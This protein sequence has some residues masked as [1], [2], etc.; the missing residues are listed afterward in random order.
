MDELDF[1][2]EIL[3]PA[4]C[5][6]GEF[7]C[8]IGALVVLDHSRAGEEDDSVVATG[9]EGCGEDVVG[10]GGL[11]GD[12]GGEGGD[13]APVCAIG[14]GASGDQLRDV[15]APVVA[16]SGKVVTGVLVVEFVSGADLGEVFVVGAKGGGVFELLEGHP[17]GDG[18]WA[19]V[20][21][22]DA[23][24]A[25]GFGG[26]AVADGGGEVV[27]GIVPEGGEAIVIRGGGGG[28]AETAGVVGGGAF[29]DTI[30]HTDGLA[31]VF[32]LECLAAWERWG[33]DIPEVAEDDVFANPLVDEFAVDME[34]DL[35]GVGFGGC[36]IGWDG[37][38][39]FFHTGGDGDGFF[40][41]A[42]FE[43][44]EALAFF[45]VSGV[46]YG[47]AE[48]GDGHVCAEH[49]VVSE[50]SAKERE[51]AVFIG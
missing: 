1:S 46:E 16:P 28:D 3:I 51:A 40:D 38:A 4:E 26:D 39:P 34:A 36:G 15:V 29:G 50:L 13:L 48:D 6:G 41:V 5:E 47:C 8:E 10:V 30:D 23:G 31:G 19:A 32:Q 24:G 12:I 20:H 9:D 37:D 11:A 22:D 45:L 42:E 44:D 17:A 49:G 2:A 35:K 18:D 43:V 25:F 7:G 14:C 33:G 21:E 27:F